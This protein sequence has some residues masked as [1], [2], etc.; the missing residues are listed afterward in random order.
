MADILQLR[1]E[2]LGVT[3]LVW[4]RLLVPASAT[5][6]RLHQTLQTAFGWQDRHLH[7]FAVGTVAFGPRFPDLDVLKPLED[8]A[9]ARL[10]RCLPSGIREFDYR[11]DFGD[12]WHVRLVVEERLPGDPDLAYP[13]CTAGEQAG[14]PEDV[15]GP[16]GY[17][18]FLAA[19]ANP[20]HAQHRDYRTW[21]GGVFDPAGFDL[22]AINRDLRRGTPRR[23]R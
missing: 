18:D 3:P 14:P 19:L 23:R 8:E 1:A 6:G 20:R 5:L 12:D 4:R 2:L 16:P 7:Q 11:Y 9:R 22:N 21:I 10:D 17:A 13:L 15:G